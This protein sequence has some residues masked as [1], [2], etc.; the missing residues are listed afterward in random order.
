MGILGNM[1]MMIEGHLCLKSLCSCYQ[2]RYL[3]VKG[4]QR[5]K[6]KLSNMETGRVCGSVCVSCNSVPLR[7]S[8]KMCL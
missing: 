3:R 6:A 4:G 1:K 7:L 5:D 8:I 2:E